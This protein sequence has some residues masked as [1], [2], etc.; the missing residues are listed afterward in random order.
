[1]IG[2]IFQFGTEIIEVR[3]NG[4]N[5]YFRTGASPSFGDIDG[6]KLDKSGTMKEFPDLKDNI[7]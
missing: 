7:N 4:M 3:V 5:V 2:C 6:M 1:M